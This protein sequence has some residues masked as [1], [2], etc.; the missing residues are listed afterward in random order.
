MAEAPFSATQYIGIPLVLWVF[1]GDL[2]FGKWVAITR[3]AR[4]AFGSR[5][6]SVC[7]RP[8]PQGM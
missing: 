7:L 2:A 8:H 3:T 1:G 5:L 6:Q 4:L